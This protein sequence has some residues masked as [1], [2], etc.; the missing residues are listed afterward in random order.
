M[1]ES[2]RYTPELSIVLD[3]SCC[4]IIETCTTVILTIYQWP[5]FTFTKGK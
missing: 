1:G 5:L 2:G 4:C 3:I